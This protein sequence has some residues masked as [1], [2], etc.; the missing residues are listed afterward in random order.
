[1][2]GMKVGMSQT[3]QEQGLKALGLEKVGMALEGLMAL[4]AVIGFLGDPAAAKTLVDGV[5]AQLDEKLSTVEAR[6]TAASEA[7]EKL[8]RDQDAF[9][10]AADET[11]FRLAQRKKEIDS[12][13]EA[14]NLA[15]EAVRGREKAVS[16][17]EASVS[18]REA[19]VVA[20][21]ASLAADEKRVATRTADL[22]QKADELYKRTLT[23]DERE[24]VLNRRAEAVAAAAKALQ[25]A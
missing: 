20:R 4:R 9:A 13:E 7:Q 25:G 19:D 11:K 1:M 8:D 5:L 22:E 21:S 14:A 3:A 17:L 18:V 16:A 24:A 23:A 6:G 15:V 10:A 2:V 12:K